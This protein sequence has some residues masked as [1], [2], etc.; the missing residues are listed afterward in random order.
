MRPIT[1]TL[2]AGM[3]LTAGCDAGSQAASPKGKR[4]E[5]LVRVAPAVEGT[6]TTTLYFPGEVRTEARARLAAGAEGEVRRVSVRVGTPVERGQVVVAVDARLARAAAAVAEAQLESARQRGLLADEEAA[7]LSGLEPGTVSD[8]EVIRARTAAT[9]AAAEVASSEALVEQRRAELARLRVTAPFAGVVS[10]RLVD[11][12]DWVSAGDPV[13]E[14]V[15]TEGLEVIVDGSK[16]L[17]GRVDAGDSVLIRTSAG[18]VEGRVGGVVPALDRVSRT[19]RVRVNP[20]S[21]VELLAGEVVEVGFRVTLDDGGL[22][23]PMDA[24]LESPDESRVIQVEDGVTR[25]HAVRVLGR[26]GDQA[27]IEA[28]GLEAEDLVVTRGNE[29]L[30]PGQEVRIETTAED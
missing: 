2:L 14:L 16:A 25:L 6:L 23:V 22:L 5:S 4:R 21:D 9:V 28:E 8:L 10:A 29:R 17:A 3:A 12:G 15:S 20:S 7:R 19:L 1:A 26:S 13:L 11:P 24:L 30:R 27:L 18:A